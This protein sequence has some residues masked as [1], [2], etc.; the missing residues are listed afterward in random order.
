MNILVTGGSSGLGRAIV[1]KLSESH[2]NVVLFTYCCNQESANSLLEKYPND[3]AFQVDF[4]N[5]DSIGKFV[6]DLE[7][8]Q[9]DVLVNNAYA[10]T[11]QGARVH[12]TDI[13]EYTTAFKNNVI[14]LI[15]VTQTCIKGMRKRKFGKIINIITSSVIDTPPIGYSVYASTKAY[16]RQFSK[17]ISKEYASF[18]ITSNCV[19]PD[20][21][22]TDFSILDEYQL[23]KM[24]ETHPLKKL[25]TP[26]E[27]ASIVVYM[28]NASQQLNGV[29]IPINAGQHI[30]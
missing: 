19:L 23:G 26:E 6:K 14:P 11:A 27:V 25:L 7:A 5:E 29:E 18:N 30:V 20:Y 13:S 1:E 8:M 17:S 10:G 28:L 21:M 3:R 2:E 24:M 22:A 12:Q 15:N 9:V 4:C 16:I